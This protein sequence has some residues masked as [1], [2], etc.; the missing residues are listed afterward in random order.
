[1][2]RLRKEEEAHAYERMLHPPPPRETFEQRFPMS[3][4]PYIQTPRIDPADDVDD[5]SY[6]EVHR[7]II[8][9]INVLISIVACSVFIWMAAR[10]WSVPQRLG[11]S[12]SG[13][14]L[15][16]VAEVVIYSGYLRRIKEA[17]VKEKKKPEIKEII[18]T[19]VI[20]GSS[21]KSAAASPSLKK[22]GQEGVRYRKGKHR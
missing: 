10:H 9:I 11:L 7:Q 13:S 8:L 20:E 4:L 14:G 22:E 3:Q 19:W 6:E 17:K 18:E 12:M 2:A 16:A 21:S 1:M 15:I 5:V